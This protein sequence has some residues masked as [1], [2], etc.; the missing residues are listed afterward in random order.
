MPRAPTL[1]K[2]TDEAGLEVA[3]SEQVSGENIEGA[4]RGQKERPSS[5]RPTPNKAAGPAPYRPGGAALPEQLALYEGRSSI[6]DGR[7]RQVRQSR[8]KS[9]VGIGCPLCGSEIRVAAIALTMECPGC[10]A[11]VDALEVARV[12]APPPGRSLSPAPAQIEPQSQGAEPIFPETLPSFFVRPVRTT[13]ETSRAP[14]P[15]NRM[16]VVPLVWIILGVTVLLG[17][18]AGAGYWRIYP[19]QGEGAPEVATSLKTP[20]TIALTVPA[21]I[22][23]P[24]PRLLLGLP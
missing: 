16:H 12:V 2:A 13:E 5:D 1:K 21:M 19:K 4:R 18:V 17:A 14:T 23:P 8:R 20:P 15:T 6:V 24:P 10:H 11:I 3:W 22:P 9:T 7:P